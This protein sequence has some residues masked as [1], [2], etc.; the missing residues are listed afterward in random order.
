MTSIRLP[1]MSPVPWVL[2]IT[3]TPKKLRVRT[4]I[5]LVSVQLLTAVSFL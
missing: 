1:R 3:L 4:R 2:V 5:P